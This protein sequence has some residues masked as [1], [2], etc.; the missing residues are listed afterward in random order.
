MTFSN[1][2]K[3]K[4]Y[5]DKSLLIEKTNEII[6]S[7]ES[8]LCVSRP[9]RFGKSTDSCMLAAYYSKGADSSSIFN[10]LNI[11]Q[12][13]SYWEHLNK[14]NDLFEYAGLFNRLKILC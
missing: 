11:A 7:N 6:C 2:L 13:D 3:N 1:K 12:S 9:R 14:H 10:S 5:V 8:K 4:I